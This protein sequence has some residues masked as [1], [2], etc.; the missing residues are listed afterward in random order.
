MSTKK[1]LTTT[2]DEVVASAIKNINNETIVITGGDLQVTLKK[3]SNSRNNKSNT[4]GRNR[5]SLKQWCQESDLNHKCIYNILKNTGENG[6]GWFS[7]KDDS[8]YFQMTKK[9]IVDIYGGYEYT[10]S[11]VITVIEGSIYLDE[12]HEYFDEMIIEIKNYSTALQCGG[13]NENLKNRKMMFSKNELELAGKA[14]I[15]LG[16]QR[17]KK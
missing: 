5:L 9:G 14:S 4:E 17:I 13:Y 15:K 7:K 6:L 8:S 11:P 10:V 12:T 1:E 2:L 16:V 3:L